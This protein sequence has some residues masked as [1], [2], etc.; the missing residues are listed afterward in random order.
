MRQSSVWIELAHFFKLKA[1]K[2]TKKQTKK[3]KNKKTKKHNNKKTIKKTKNDQKNVFTTL[4]E[5]QYTNII[6]K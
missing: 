4:V 2:L 5:T 6:V 1:H 3:N